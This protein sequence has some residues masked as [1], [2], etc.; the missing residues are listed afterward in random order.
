[1]IHAS[2]ARSSGRGQSGRHGPLLWLALGVVWFSSI[3]SAAQ[4][5]ETVPLTL[6]QALDLAARQNPELL[7]TRERAGAQAHRAAAVARATW[8]RLTVTTGWSRS[9]NAAQTFANK[10]NAGEFTQDDFT[11]D[12]LNDPHALSHQTTA[13]GIEAPLDVFGRGRALG[14]AQ[15]AAGRAQDA[16]FREA[17]LEVRLRVAEAYLQGSLAGRALAV[18]AAAL[19]GA[20]AREADIEA[21]VAQGAALT[22]DLLRA[23]A[24]RRQREADMAER[25]ADL[26][27]A[28]AALARA[29]GAPPATRY[30][31]VDFPDSI[32]SLDGDEAGWVAR[33]LE[34]RPALAAA[35][36][37]ADGARWA[38]RAERRGVFPDLAAYGQ[39]QD[40]RN[41]LSGGHR[42]AAV[43]VT[44]RWTAFDAARPRRLA[45]VE[46]EQRAAEHDLR[47]AR[48][49][50][51]LEIVTAFRRAEIARERHAATS[52]GAEE[53]REA[54]RVL[55]ERRQAGLATL[56]DELETEAASLAAELEELRAATE[57]VL[58]DAVLQRAAGR[59]D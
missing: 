29:V 21:R 30:E 13:L 38:S 43:G 37:R 58:A 47:A 27:L 18:T 45:A 46:A 50:V 28:Q 25:R 49:Q 20:R 40:D 24:R 2:C 52:G 19:A 26:E 31:P 57:V 6:A 10:L 22:A 1:M 23:R 51:H 12:R 39:L 48:D 11:L 35:A 41:D 59:I 34:G 55:Q 16:A 17:L 8:P 9:D 15:R 44:A 32:H 53:G 4:A 56:T 33:A 36:E 7:A 5:Q 14:A 3:A 42:S 54:L